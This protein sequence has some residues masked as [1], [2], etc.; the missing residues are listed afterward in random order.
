MQDKEEVKTE[1][2]RMSTFSGIF[3]INSNCI[4]ENWELESNNW[5]SYHVDKTKIVILFSIVDNLNQFEF[6]SN[7]EQVKN[8][9]EAQQHF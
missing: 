7:V 5:F 9:E 3:P 6:I 8:V 2:E 1:G 4:E